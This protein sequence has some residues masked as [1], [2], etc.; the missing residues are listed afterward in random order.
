MAAAAEQHDKD[1]ADARAAG[2]TEGR[3]AGLKEGVI[4]E[5]ARISAI[6]ASDEGKKRPKAALSAALK[7]EMTVEQASAFL[8]DL[9]EE[10]PE[11]TTTK[12]KANEQS[13]FDK[14][15]GNGSGV[16]AGAGDGTEGQEPTAK[17]KA[18][19]LLADYSMAAGIPPEK[20]A[21]A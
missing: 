18:N 17:Q 19:Q 14:A 20:K 9:A 1:I 5:R 3:A 8:A 21:A 2:V 7:T 11:A 10:K 16:E 15:M 4:A 12:T 13:H 6:L